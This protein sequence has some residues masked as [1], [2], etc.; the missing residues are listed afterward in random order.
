[1][2]DWEKE[3]N[4]FICN[5]N[6]MLKEEQEDED[7]DDDDDEEENDWKKESPEFFDSIAKCV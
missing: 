6:E 5:K 2:A 3:W 4:A 7:D 1:M